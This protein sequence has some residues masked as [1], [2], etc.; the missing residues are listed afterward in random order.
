MA[1]MEWDINF[2]TGITTIDQQH[3][4]IIGLINQLYNGL[5]LGENK[6]SIEEHLEELIE[7]SRI[8]FKTEEDLFIKFEYILTLEHTVEHRRFSFIAMM[9]NQDYLDGKIVHPL[10]ILDFLT[11]WFIDHIVSQD[12]AYAS[13]LVE[14]LRGVNV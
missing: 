6:A 4:K 3:K 10:Q 11:V 5:K 2:S 12:H 9:F 14:K 1:L 8:H 13:F 7:H